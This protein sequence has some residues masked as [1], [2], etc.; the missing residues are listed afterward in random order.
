MIPLPF[1][2]RSNPMKITTPLGIALAWGTALL[3]GCASV[4]ALATIQLQTESAGFTGCQLP[5]NEISNVHAELKALV[6]N[7]T[8][9]E[10]TY[11]CVR[12]GSNG[13]FQTHCA[14]AVS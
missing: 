11:Q 14:P 4:S 7:A 8:C 13:G 1:Q 12:V 5:A 3:S 10:K 9:K 2:E 6:W